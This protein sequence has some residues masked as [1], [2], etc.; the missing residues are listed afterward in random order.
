[1]S[2]AWRGA[3]SLSAR[4]P[5]DSHGKEHG[6]NLLIIGGLLAVGVLAIVGAVLLS[7]SEQ[8]A[9]TMRRNQERLPALPTN[10]NQTVKLRPA[11]AD[12]PATRRSVAEEDSL[13]TF[14]GEKGLSHLNGQFR[15]LASEIRS[16]HQQ[17]QNLEHRLGVLT[18]T[19]DHIER[20]RSGRT[21]VEEDT[22][23]SSD[24]TTA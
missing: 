7:L 4:A 1:M 13:T 3:T 24:H 9:E 5:P 16:L 11:D 18:D 20:S 17:A 21:S 8:K 22:H 19:V 6:V 10:R 12:E 15:E 14:E 2:L 23:T